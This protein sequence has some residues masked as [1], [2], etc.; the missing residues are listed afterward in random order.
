MARQ[1]KKT[2]DFDV[3]L[4]NVIRAKRTKIRMSQ[5]ELAEAS[6]IAMSNLQRRESGKIEITVS[7]IK[8]IA[9]ALGVPAHELVDEALKDFGGMEKLIAEHVGMSE[10]PVS[11]E[12][13]REKKKSVADMTV[14]EIESMQTK[15]AT[16]NVELDQDEPEAP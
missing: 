5:T 4:G 9:E 12:A 11:L 1:P 15:A 14:D 13:H 16:H 8:R 6:G 10:A 2:S 3:R 7:E